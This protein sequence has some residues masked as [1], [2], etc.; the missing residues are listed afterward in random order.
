M[1]PASPDLLGW[2]AHELSLT[3]LEE[4]EDGR[5][6]LLAGSPTDLHRPFPEI[7]AEV[8]ACDLIPVEELV[9]RARAG[10]PGTF[11]LDASCERPGVLLVWSGEQGRTLA[12]Y[13]PGS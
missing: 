8:A 3:L 7:L 1:V 2:I 11:E 9:E 5:V 12:L 4:G 13:S 10:A 6:R